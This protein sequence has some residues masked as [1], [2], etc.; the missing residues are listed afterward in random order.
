MYEGQMVQK[1]DRL[2]GT[3]L[4]VI[5]LNLGHMVETSLAGWLA[6]GPRHLK[7]VNN[8]PKAEK[9]KDGWCLIWVHLEEENKCHQKK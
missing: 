6:E 5:P 9:E 2:A 3:H 7:L 1:I 8:F 4:N